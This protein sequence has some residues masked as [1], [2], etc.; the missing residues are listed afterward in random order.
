MKILSI[1]IGKVGDIH[2]PEGLGSPEV[3]AIEK[4]SS[5]SSLSITPSNKVSIKS[6]DKR[7]Y[8][9]I[10]KRSVS[11]LDQP[12]PVSIDSLGVRGDEQANLSVHGGVDKALYV[13]PQEHYPFWQQCLLNFGH[14]SATLDFGAFGENLSVQG[15]TEK[16]VYIGDCW[17][18]GSV[19]A[20]VV[21]FREPCFKF[22]IK[23]GW[24]GASKAMI[25][26]RYFGW[27]LR[28][29]QAGVIKAGDAVEVLA[30]SREMTVEMQG[31]FFYSKVDPPDMWT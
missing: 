2:D 11:N 3:N 19:T 31:R 13:Y 25:Q 20:Q 15:F 14:P 21:K 27:Y 6:T 8:S 28:V 16:D 4:D 5:D 29:L 18:V 1:N 10:H 22:N 23:M 30:G 9:A 24:G 7:I 12:V 17:Q 26:S